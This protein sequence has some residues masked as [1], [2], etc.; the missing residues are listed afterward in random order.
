MQPSP[1]TTDVPWAYVKNGAVVCARWGQMLR[2]RVWSRVPSK[3]GQ[4]KLRAVERSGTRLS[5]SQG[6]QPTSAI[7]ASLVPGLRIIRKGLRKP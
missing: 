4:P 1:G 5:S 3:H 2:S 6:P 7:Q